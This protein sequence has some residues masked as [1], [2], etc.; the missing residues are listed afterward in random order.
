MLSNK[1]LGHFRQLVKDYTPH[2][3][4]VMLESYFTC[5]TCGIKD[6]CPVG[7]EYDEMDK[8]GWYREPVNSCVDVLENYI[9]SG[10]II[11]KRKEKKND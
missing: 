4:A 3:L 6:R 1:E 5:D 7:K 11:D 2:N 10:M 8:Y 9:K